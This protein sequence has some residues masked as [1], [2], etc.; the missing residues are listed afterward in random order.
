[1]RCFLVAFSLVLFA[2]ASEM[3]DA[4][5]QMPRSFSKDAVPRPP[6]AMTAHR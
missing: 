2:C 4:V 3:P 5:V 1:M 6:P